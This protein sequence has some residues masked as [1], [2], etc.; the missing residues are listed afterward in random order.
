MVLNLNPRSHHPEFQALVKI[1]QAIASRL[2]HRI[3]LQRIADAARE[4]TNSQRAVVF[5]LEGDEL[6]I[7]AASGDNQAAPMTG[8]R[9]P[10]AGSLAGL[11]LESGAPVQI[12]NA[13]LDPHVLA[14]PRRRTLVERTGVQTLL[15]VPLVADNQAIGAI[16]LSDKVEG[17]YNEADQHLLMLLASS[18]VIALENARLAGAFVAVYLNSSAINLS[19]ILRRNWVLTLV[20]TLLAGGFLVMN[21]LSQDSSPRSKGAQLIIDVIWQ[22]GVYGALDALLLSVVPVLV[23][24]QSFQA[25]EQALSWT[26]KIALGVLALGASALVTAAYHWGYPEFRGKEV[27]KPVFGVAISTLAYLITGNPIASIGSHMMMHIAAV[28]HGPATTIQLPPHY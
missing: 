20:F 28:L 13:S 26:Q 8:Y 6:R 21:V 1:Q 24:W 27:I 18:A 25:Q 19:T 14:D 10:V 16:S 12:A 3:V 7:V 22:G 23:V 4:L 11:A 2:E 17:T 15:I 9:M 5:L